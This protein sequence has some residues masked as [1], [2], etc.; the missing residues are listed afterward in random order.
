MPLL[1]D[2]QARGI[3]QLLLSRGEFREIHAFPQ[4]DNPARRVF[5]DAKLSTTVFIYQK[6]S[7]ER[8]TGSGFRSQVHPAQFIEAGSPTLSL[9]SNSIP[10][11]DPGN[12]TIVSCSQQDWD[13]ATRILERPA[14][15]RLGSYCTSFQGEVNETNEGRRSGVLH[16][17]PAPGRQLMLRGSNVCLYVLREASQGEAIY[18]DGAAF[19]AGKAP[20]SKAYHSRVPRV[21]FQRSSPQNNYRR[22]IAAYV[23]AGEFCFDTVSYIPEIST[24]RL[25]IDFLLGLLNSKLIDW[26]FRLGSTNSKV[27]EYQFNNLPCPI[28]RDT[29]TSEDTALRALAHQALEE[30]PLSAAEVL[31]PAWASAPFSPAAKD[32]IEVLSGRVRA[33]E[34]TRGQISR[35]DRSRLFEEA[36]P[37]QRALDLILFRMAGLSNA[38]IAGLEERLRKML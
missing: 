12:H 3:R 24:T 28:F 7:P 30:S 31:M 29:V 8:R 13:L 11:Y 27:N 22:V 33:L 2:E 5:R 16:R 6:L 1:G 19:L 38:E 9:N 17:S 26:Y 23:P 36:E 15:G 37:Y 21:G 10:L 32:I 14:M 4:K 25:S 35:R 20:D 18:I 34:G